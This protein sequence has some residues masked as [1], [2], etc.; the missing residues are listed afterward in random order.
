MELK[1][2]ILSILLMPVLGCGG[3][4][5]SPPPAPT[6]PPEQSDAGVIAARD[7]ERNKR[8]QA[9]SNT[10]LTGPQGATAPASVAVK[11]L[12]GA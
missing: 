6:P 5:P 8:R 9:T 11:S 2:Y 1:R 12:L 4:A 3:S 7:S 10:I